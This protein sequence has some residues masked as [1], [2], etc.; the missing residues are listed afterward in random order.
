MR[1]YLKLQIVLCCLSAATYAGADTIVSTQPLT[2]VSISTAGAAR[3]TATVENSALDVKANKER[4]WRDSGLYLLPYKPNYFLPYAQVL[5]G[6]PGGGIDGNDQTK[7]QNV[8]AKFQISFRA[9]LASGLFWGYG[10]LQIAYT[11]LSLYQIYN[12]RLSAPFRDTIYEPEAMLRFD[13]PFRIFG[14]D[15]RTINLSIDHQSNG[16][17]DPDSRSWNRFYGQFVAGRGNAMV[18]LKPWVRLPEE[19]ATDDNPDIERYMGNFEL[20]TAYAWKNTVAS[21]L[22]RNNLQARNKGAVEAD[23]SFPLLR[24]LRGYFQYFNGYGETLIVYNQPSTRIGL[25]LSFSDWL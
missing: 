25:G 3:P 20:V 18:S 14:W 23:Y 7:L 13:T 6:R 4:E 19:T 17:S 1:R 2:T 10:T 21:I 22:F 24:H 12:Q 8:E 15:L 5:N 16:R 11:Q 9:P